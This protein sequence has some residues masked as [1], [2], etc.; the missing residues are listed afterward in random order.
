MQTEQAAPPA[1]FKLEGRGER[2]KQCEKSLKTRLSLRNNRNVFSDRRE[3][4]KAH[5][6]FQVDARLH[7]HPRDDGH[8]MPMVLLLLMMIMIVMIV[9]VMMMMM[10]MLM[11]LRP[12]QS[13][14]GAR[15]SILA[16]W[17]NQV[18]CTMAPGGTPWL[19]PSGEGSPGKTNSRFL[20][21]GTSALGLRV[22]ASGLGV[23]DGLLS[24][25][26]RAS[27][28]GLNPQCVDGMSLGLRRCDACGSH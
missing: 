27:S 16:S 26:F 2:R 12:V 25:S 23:W 1:F 14:S 3:K 22:S 19:L 21:S 6:C 11:M 28:E 24:L 4:K 5:L 17:L 7:Q 9:I 18:N 13:C 10:L 8:V 15:K 20:R